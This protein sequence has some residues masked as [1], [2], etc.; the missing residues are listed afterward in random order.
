MAKFAAGVVDAAEAEQAVVE[1][2]DEVW[3][4]SS[5]AGRGDRRTRPCDPHSP[6]WIVAWALDETGTMHTARGVRS[7]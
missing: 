5:A 6:A 2:M 1:V 3:T 4:R 7:A